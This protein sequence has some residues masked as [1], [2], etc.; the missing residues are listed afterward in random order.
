[1]IETF[2]M[3]ERPR[4]LKPANIYYHFYSSATQGALRALEQVHDWCLQQPL[5][6]MTAVEYARVVRDSYNTYLYPSGNREWL[7]INNGKLRTFRIPLGMGVPDLARSSGVTGSVPFGDVLY[8]H[9]NGSQRTR[10][11]LADQ[12][13]GH[14]FLESSQG[15]IAWKEFTA[16]RL[17]FSVS[18]LRPKHTVVI[19]GAKA[20]RD[21]KVTIDGEVHVLKSDATGRVEI[22][23][24]GSQDVKIEG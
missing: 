7:L 3:T 5:H 18:E 14:L 16:N 13:S 2:E 12:S 4:R 6:S 22:Q 21:A 23:L 9:T 11:V 8:I 19:G 15:E 1:L 17:H 24:S 20:N 10:L